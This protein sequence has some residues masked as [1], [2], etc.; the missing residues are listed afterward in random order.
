MGLPEVD[1]VEVF[2][3]SAAFDHLERSGSHDSE[4]DSRSVIQT[5]MDTASRIIIPNG[6]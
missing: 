6:G 2:A 1:A 3:G 5:Q 4:L